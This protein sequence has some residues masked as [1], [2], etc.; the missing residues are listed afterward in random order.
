VDQQIAPPRKQLPARILRANTS[1]SCIQRVVQKVRSDISFILKL[2]ITSIPLFCSE[3]KCVPDKLTW[4]PE[5]VI[6]YEDEVKFRVNS[7]TP[8]RGEYL[9]KDYFQT[10]KSQML[11][12]E[13]TRIPQPDSMRLA[14]NQTTL[15]MK[16]VVH[17][18]F[19]T[20]PPW[21]SP[22]PA[23]HLPSSL[24]LCVTTCCICKPT[25]NLS[26]S[27]PSPGWLLA[28]TLSFALFGAFAAQC[29]CDGGI[30]SN[31]L[32]LSLKL[33]KAGLLLFSRQEG[34]LLVCR[35]NCCFSAR[36]L[37]VRRQLGRLGR[38]IWIVGAGLALAVAICRWTAG[39]TLG[40]L[41]IA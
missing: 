34:R 3:I 32:S 37:A 35:G 19:A 30:V 25:S 11:L 38:Q 24:I 40:V 20:A 28:T 9:T 22:L 8:Q 31:L 36:Y 13:Q 29:L 14:T 27:T 5:G 6:S 21:N 10:A 16:R 39:C 41:V 4:G 12:K 18:P 33:S 1:F 23:F 15:D 26:H 17:F 2:S 7:Y